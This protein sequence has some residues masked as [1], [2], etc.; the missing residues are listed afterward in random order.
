MGGNNLLRREKSTNIPKLKPFHFYKP[1][2][3][4]FSGLIT[5]LYDLLNY[6]R[7]NKELLKLYDTI[8]K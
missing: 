6:S 7:H 8:F 4:P 5:I 3:T 1:A 2:G